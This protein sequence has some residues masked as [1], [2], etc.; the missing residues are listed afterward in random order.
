MGYAVRFED[1]T[2][3]R[4][5]IKYLTGARW[6]AR[7]GG[8]QRGA[9]RARVVG[10]VRAGTARAGSG[11]GRTGQRS[12]QPTQACCMP[13][14]RWLLRAPRWHADGTLLRE[15]L[16]DTSLNHYRCRGGGA[17]SA[18]H[19]CAPSRQQPQRHHS[20]SPAPRHFAA[21]SI[22]VLDEA[23]ERSLN[24]DILFGLLKSLV[25]H[26]RA[27]GGVQGRRAR[28]GTRLPRPAGTHAFFAP[29]R[30]APRP[31]PA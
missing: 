5:R 29:R 26:R 14:A 16:E 7:A 18:P 3:R 31:T 6:V 12:C 1:R 24:T 20:S 25:V 8:R 11:R 27:R 28:A 2:S 30:P 17:R 23:H 4:T 19:A 10:G 15:C 9:A 13:G 22:L 21:P